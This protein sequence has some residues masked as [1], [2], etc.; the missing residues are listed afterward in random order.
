[1]VLLCWVRPLKRTFELKDYLDSIY[2]EAAQYNEPPNYPVS[3][4][5]GG[6]DAAPKGSDILSKIFGGVVA[7]MGDKPC[8]DMDEFYDPSQD[9]SI[10]WR[11]QV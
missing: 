1:M 7:F 3:V 9:T 5:C 10:A 2:C 6:I 8:Y 11:W 4:V